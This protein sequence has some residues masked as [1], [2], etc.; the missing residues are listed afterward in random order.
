MYTQLNMEIKHLALLIFFYSH[1]L[2]GRLLHQSGCLAIGE[3]NEMTT[4]A[5]MPG[6]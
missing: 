3:I 4:E 6:S 5:H 2:K 1:I